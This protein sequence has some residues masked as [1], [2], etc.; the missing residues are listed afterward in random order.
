MSTLRWKFNWPQT[1][2][3]FLDWWDRRGVLLGMWGALPAKVQHEPVAS[4]GPVPSEGVFTHP[5]VWAAVDHHRL[6]RQRFPAD[7]LPIV[8]PCLG[9]GSLVLFLGSEPHFTPETVWFEPIWEHC[10][11]PES[12]PPLRFNPD[13]R[14][15]RITEETSRRQTDLARGRYIAACPDL[16][17]NIDILSALRS[18]TQLMIDLVD[19]PQWVKQKVNEITAAWFEAFGRVYDIIRGPDGSSAFDAFRLWG[20]GKTAKLQCD[21]SALI[22]ADMF[23]EF[24]VP[25]LREQCQYLDHS[26][27]H[28]DGTQC[29]QHLDALFE[30]EEL[31]AI[32]WTPQAGLEGGGSPRWYD[33]YRRILAAGKS[34]QAVGVKPAEVKPLI[35]AIGT[36]GVYLLVRFETIDQVDEVEKAIGR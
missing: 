1:R 30:I 11:Q 2:K 29:I 7:I 18:P 28:L 36:H 24:V 26:M 35:D 12:L 27:Y 5:A 8:S 13:C 31:D 22:S 16:I 25:S 10:D 32:E 17:E 15:W 33:V 20:P 9:A 21:A 6:S 19:R 34:I 14:W 23:R 3:R 4:P